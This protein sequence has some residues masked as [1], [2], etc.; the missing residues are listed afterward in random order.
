MFFQSP[1][2]LAV[3][4]MIELHD[5]IFFFLI[6]IF[7]FVL[8]FFFNI[9]FDFSDR[10]KSKNITNLLEKEHGYLQTYKITHL[11]LIEVIWT[12]IPVLILTVIA[13]P[14]FQL[15]YALDVISNPLTTLKCIGNQWYWRYEGGNPYGKNPYKLYSV[16]V[17]DIHF[18]N[19]LFQKKKIG[20]AYILYSKYLSYYYR[21]L[22][23]KNAEM[24]RKDYVR[25]Q[26]ARRWRVVHM[27]WT[28]MGKV[29]VED[30][31]KFY[32]FARAWLKFLNRRDFY[33]FELAKA[34]FKPF[35]FDSYLLDVDELKLGY[36]RLLEVD[37]YAI[38]PAHMEIRILVTATDVLHSFAIPALGIKIDAVPGR[39][40][41]FGIRCRVPGTYFGQC[42]ELCGVGHGFMPIK[43]TFQNI[44]R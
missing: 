39:L 8:W 15:L 17:T 37:S 6:L 43:I 3:E 34:I 2:S 5:Y 23:I 19:P 33:N 29:D 12:I 44:L 18:E 13:I 4:R 21:F 38:L 14:S 16:A 9:L 28:F 25:S 7:T 11:G 26:I 36:F 20:K 1:A 35:Q 31:S 27:L 42:S 40:N 41:Q 32:F 30:Y 24:V 22:T 10:R